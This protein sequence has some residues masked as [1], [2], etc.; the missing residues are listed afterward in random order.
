VQNSVVDARARDFATSASADFLGAL[1]VVDE[2]GSILFWNDGAMSL[3]GYSS[4]EVVGRSIFETIVPPDLIDEQR[5]WL[6]A[7]VE[8]GSAIHELMRR[9]KDDIRIWVEASVRA[10]R[11]ADGEQMMVLNERDITRTKYEREAQILQTR[12]RGVLEAGPDATV[13]VDSTGR[14]VLVNSKTEALFGYA[15]EELLGQFVT[16]LVPAFFQDS[17]TGNGPPY[18]R[19][20]R[21]RPMGT[22]LE[23]SGRRMDGREFPV[24][25]SLSP[26]SIEGTH[27]AMAALRDVSGTK[28]TEEALKA[29]NAELESF[30]YS[31]SHDLR[32]PIR[33]IEG[34]ARI[35]GEHLGTDVDP[36]ADQYLLR[37]QDG[38]RQ[39]GRLVDDLLHLA[40]L[41]RQHAR[42][43]RICLHSLIDEVLMNVRAGITD[44]L[45][46]WRVDPLPD[47]V[48]DPGLMTVV[49]T[50]LLSNAVKYT[51]P[52]EKAVIEIG[53]TFRDGQSTIY[54]RDN[55]V[56]FDMKYA[57]KL[58][59][60]FQ[61][62][63]RA[64]E[65][66]GTGVGLATVHHIIRKH[67]GRIW[68]ESAPDRGATFFFT[69]GSSPPNEGT[70]TG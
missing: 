7:S 58:F 13:L 54:V 27:L 56:G 51:R 3:F 66:E 41:G 33:Q 42:P 18:F 25:I 62:L 50:N 52:R 60:V 2:D 46:E 21:A 45:I 63:H 19:E 59:G 38:A 9:R 65:F 64:D 70:S 8:G 4:D 36:Q 32:A 48:C 30:T 39:M 44:R 11:D 20:P 6:T 10:H 31:V 34:F 16:L 35:L 57:D 24:E 5:H 23:L 37:I 49:F 61:R 29:A 22:G 26:L 69:V 68:A 47:V 14:M 53:Q 40:Q 12:F 17:D 15:R 55:G 67:N 43:R 28:N 1:I